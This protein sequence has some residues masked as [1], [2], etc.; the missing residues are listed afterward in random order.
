MIHE[1]W[2]SLP[3]FPPL[4]L[5]LTARLEVLKLHHRREREGQEKDEG[6]EPVRSV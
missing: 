5:L 1:F 3:P 2:F 4:F 6:A